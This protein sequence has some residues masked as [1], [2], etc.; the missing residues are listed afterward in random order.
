MDENQLIAEIRNGNA[1]S[2]ISRFTAARPGVGLETVLATLINAGLKAD[3]ETAALDWLKAEPGHPVAHLALAQLYYGDERWLDAI[4]HFSFLRDTNPADPIPHG[5]LCWAHAMTRRLAELR[6]VVAEAGQ[7]IAPGRNLD[8]QA[9]QIAAKY[10]SDED[11]AAFQ[12]HWDQVKASTRD[13]R[14]AFAKGPAVVTWMPDTAGAS[15][16]LQGASLGIPAETAWFLVDGTER[17]PAEKRADDT[18]AV[19]SAEIGK[20]PGQVRSAA[21]VVHGPDG[22]RYGREVAFECRDVD[23][24]IAET[25]GAS[26]I[27]MT[28]AALAGRVAA[29]ADA[30]AYRFEYGRSPDRLDRS[31]DWAPLPGALNARLAASPQSTSK[32]CRLYVGAVEWDQTDGVFY[33]RSPFGKDPNH[34]SGIGFL[35]HLFTLRQNSLQPDGFQEIQPHEGSD[36]RDAEFTAALRTRDFDSKGFLHCL[37]AGHGGNFWMLTGE[38]IDLSTAGPDGRLDIALTL[39]PTPELWTHF[40]NNPKEQANYERY[41][42]GPLN[43]ALCPHVGSL[44]FEGAFGDWRDAPEGDIAFERVTLT[45]RDSNALSPANGARLVAYPSNTLCDPAALTD[46]RRGDPDD[47]WYRLGP[48]EEPL[49]FTW[50]LPR[51]VLAGRFVLH[52]DPLLPIKRATVSASRRSDPARP[53]ITA[54]LEDIPSAENILDDLPLRTVSFPGTEPVDLVRLEIEQGYSDAGVGLAGVELYAADFVPRPSAAPVTVSADIEDLEPGAEVFYRTVCRAREREEAGRTESLNL[55]ADDA[56]I[57]IE[58]QIFQATPEKTS[59]AVRGNA[60]GRETT[61]QWRADRDDWQ[62]TSFGWEKSSAHR[63][64]TLPGS[65]PGSTRQVTVRL[66]SDAGTSNETTVHWT[67]ETDR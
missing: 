5:A 31:T 65:P 57:L 48:V 25:A 21:L 16:R 30:G 7:Q 4:P 45:Y 1:V 54:A 66:T 18:V 43:D 46:G 12:R 39:R 32:L 35:D 11:K 50:Q 3:A 9:G 36:L 10:L 13:A 33:C 23:I 15:V 53:P 61:L 52:L 24:L 51:P 41:Y 26:A 42:Y 20:T 40:G 37:G 28:G 6:H 19:W 8:W 2:A 56:P 67:V 47:C 64:I 22:D 44:P 38:P 17:V 58:A 14:S 62:E 29:G 49:V 27:G 55:P 63:Y 59:I 60:M 34:M